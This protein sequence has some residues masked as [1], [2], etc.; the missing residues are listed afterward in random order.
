M[1]CGCGS[2]KSRSATEQLLVSDAVDRSIASIDFRDLAGA[3]V[4]LDTQYVKT[5]KSLGFV[6]ADYIISSL[7]QQMLAANCYLEE[8]R[9]KAE[10]IAEVRVGAL[11]MDAHNVTYG[12]P[13]SNS[14]SV[15]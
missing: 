4:Y 2:T 14:L 10:Y 11:G 12:I 9:T 3:S 7:R 13:A 8:D 15:S 1:L 5:V 6:N